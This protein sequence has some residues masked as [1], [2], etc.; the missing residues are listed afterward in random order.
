MSCTDRDAVLDAESVDPRNH[1]L[2]G[3]RI[4]TTWQI[5]LNCLCVVAMQPYV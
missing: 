4:G 1:V 5:W 2:L 3:V